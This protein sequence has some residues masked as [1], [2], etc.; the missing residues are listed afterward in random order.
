MVRPLWA[1]GFC[2]LFGFGSC[3]RPTLHGDSIASTPTSSM[4]GAAIT[5][6]QG[7]MLPSLVQVAQAV[8]EFP[9]SVSKVLVNLQYAV[10][11]SW[12]WNKTHEGHV[13]D[14]GLWHYGEDVQH[15]LGNFIE[16]RHPSYHS[17][18]DVA[19][20]LGIFLERLARKHPDRKFYGT[21]ISKVMVNA[22]KSRCPSCVAETYDLNEL[23]ASEF[24]LVPGHLPQPVDIIIVADVLYYMAWG[25]LP[26]FLNYVLPPSWTHAHR[27]AFWRHLTSLAHKEVIFSGH[28]NN[29][30]VTQYLKDMGATFIP[31]EG[32]WVT[33][34][35]AGSSQFKDKYQEQQA[36]SATFGS[37]AMYL[38]G[39]FVMTMIGY[40]V[41][42][43]KQRPP[44]KY[45]SFT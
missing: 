12:L 33:P 29:R 1:V 44:K 42:V 14:G 26:P 37:S 11:S 30:A 27:D 36:I 40:A 39:A 7:R 20:N 28:Q 2:C 5:W 41:Y 3:L 13:E 38:L 22:T 35:M 45:G 16:K 9:L 17:M 4:R 43:T 10:P 21:D 32:V 19:C 31:E 24:T 6:H 15:R 34:G 18:W 23:Q 8:K 25:G